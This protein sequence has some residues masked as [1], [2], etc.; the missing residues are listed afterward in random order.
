MSISNA[1]HATRLRVNL[2][3]DFRK[4]CHHP[5]FAQLPPL[6]NF[7]TSRI[8]L[9]ETNKSVQNAKNKQ[10]TA[11]SRLNLPPSFRSSHPLPK[12]QVTDFEREKI[13]LGNNGNDSSSGQSDPPQPIVYTNPWWTPLL[14]LGVVFVPFIV[15]G[16][17]Y[18]AYETYNDRAV[19]FPLWINSSVPLD[20]AVGFENIDVDMLKEVA[21]TNLL[22]RLNVNHEIREYFGLPITL[23]DYEL[24]DVRIQYN[25]LA[26]EGVELDFRK[27]WLK[28]IIRYREIDT[29]VLPNNVNKYVQPL[30]ARVGGGVDEDPEQDSIFA[31]DMEYKIKIRATIKVANEVL[32]RIEPGSGRITF[33]AEVELD[34]TRLM[35]I[36]SAL[37]H[38]R[39]KGGSGSGGTLEKLW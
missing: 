28:P 19:F 34:H 27:S 33:D 25:K 35:K 36:T 37:M 20:H 23:S 3:Q 22:R 38:F 13:Q 8:S 12:N 4:C 32:H 14:K 24:F 10:N 29:P 9:G 26:V 7:A 2:P 31:K 30:K 11:K 17:G 39:N 5:P 18:I 16:I 15:V 21:K 1:L 6:R